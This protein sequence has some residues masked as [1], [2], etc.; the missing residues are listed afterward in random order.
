MAVVF[1][2]VSPFWAQDTPTIRTNVNFVLI[3]VG[4][5]KK[6]GTPAP[7]LTKDNFEI[8]DNGK[9]QSISS[10]EAGDV[11]VSFAVIID[12]SGSMRPRKAAVIEA[13]RHFVDRLSPAD[14][15]AAV[16]FNDEA[17]VVHQPTL[18][19]DLGK[20]WLSH[21]EQTRPDGRTAL[22][23]ALSLSIDL[24]AASRHSR[25]VGLLLSDG[26]DTTSNSSKQEVITKLRSANVTIFSIGLFH[27][28]EPDTD[29]A[30]LEEFSRESGGTAA[31]GVTAKLPAVFDRILA[32]LRNRYVIGFQAGGTGGGEL[33][34]LRVIA[35]DREGREL[36]SRA[37][38]TYLTRGEK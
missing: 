9:K 26:S 36:Q 1:S 14:E 7:G 11:A 13:V 6:D 5:A 22:R 10:F 18:A 17:K 2:L 25:R 3:D 32:D 4:V 30:V 23:D 15:V 28:G 20:S 33:H 27:R 16:V 8:L 38:R 12:F 34:H 31:F 29:S 37:R 35:H 24:L 21:L 19:A